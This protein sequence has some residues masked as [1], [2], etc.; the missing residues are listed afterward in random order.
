VGNYKVTI[1]QLARIG[2]QTFV[3]VE[4]K[5]S[6]T[7]SG[8]FMI[9]N[10][11]SNPS[12]FAIS[13]NTDGMSLEQLRDTI[14]SDINNSGKV[15]ATIIDTGIGVEHYRL[16]IKGNATGTTN[17]FSITSS[18]SLIRDNDVNMT[19]QAHDANFSID[20]VSLKRS[21]NIIT[22][23]IDG[24]TFTLKKNVLDPVIFTV[25]NDI[26][27]IQS[28]I[29]T[30]ISSYNEMRSYINSKS[31]LDQKNPKNNGPFLG[32]STVR[33]I[34]MRLQQLM[35]G[36]ISGI[37]ENFSALHDIGITTGSDGKLNID[38]TK[39]SNTLE[40]NSEYVSKMF[41]GT[42]IISG[43][44]SRVNFELN[45]FTN[46]IG[47]LINLRVN[48]I[49]SRITNLNDRINVVER[50]VSNYEKTL[51]RQFTTLEQLISSLQTKGNAFNSI[52]A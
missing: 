33:G 29:K 21:E 5:T 7:L 52:R 6:H 45:K 14:N 32:D 8:T 19:F 20:G 10:A 34:Y 13:I 48:G 39:L 22:D 9:G 49:Q 38:D 37:T 46:P 44:A 42:N 50:R 43:I 23:V 24:V 35:T 30:F 11:A 51:V 3:G 28:N 36:E 18:S 17:D 26:G 15:T 16:Q 25:D 41:I 4:S 12:N 27:Y 2:Q 31:E 1:G 47:G 40:K